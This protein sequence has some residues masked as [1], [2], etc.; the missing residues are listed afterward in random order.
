MP[1]DIN[2]VL[3]LADEAPS[4]SAGGDSSDR[5]RRDTAWFYESRYA[6][7]YRAVSG[8]RYGQWAIGVLTGLEVLG[9]L[10]LMTDEF[11][12]GLAF[13]VLGAFSGALVWGFLAIVM[14]FMRVV[15]DNT[16]AVVPGIDD[17]QRL[18][19]IKGGG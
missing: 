2:D 5:D 17:E 11:V 13:A 3:G 7:A 19:I 18:R 14:A 6:A 8:I 10:V 9:A 16:V 4:T 15:I 12:P 1:D